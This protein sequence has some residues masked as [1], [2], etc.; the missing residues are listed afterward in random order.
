M[1]AVTTDP[2]GRVDHEPTEPQRHVRPTA[3]PEPPRSRHVSRIGA[4]P[5]DPIGRALE[6]WLRNVSVSYTHDGD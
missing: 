5:T 3:L 6:E 1:R 2:R 4:I